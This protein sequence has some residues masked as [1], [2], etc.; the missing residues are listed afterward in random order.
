MS[1]E[2]YLTCLAL[3]GTAVYFEPGL[4]ALSFVVTFVGDAVLEKMK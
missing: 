2:L 1:R 4:G 3:C